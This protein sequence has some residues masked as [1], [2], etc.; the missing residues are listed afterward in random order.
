MR[1]DEATKIDN[2]QK[3]VLKEYDE[4]FTEMYSKIQESL[5]SNFGT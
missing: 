2:A 5:E 3:E 1:K 4:L